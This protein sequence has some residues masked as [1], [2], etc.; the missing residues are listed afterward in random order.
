MRYLDFKLSILHCSFM[1]DLFPVQ[2]HRN[3]NQRKH[4]VIFFCQKFPTRL[5]FSISQFIARL[6]NFNLKV[7]KIT[8]F[9]YAGFYCIYSLYT[10]TRI[11]PFWQKYYATFSLGD[12]GWYVDKDQ[13]TFIIDMSYSLLVV[14]AGFRNVTTW[15][16]FSI[17][18]IF[19]AGFVIR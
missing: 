10:D 8:R 6:L 1:E 14:E 11:K 3:V 17:S 7:L 4:T 13:C 12:G 16:C 2:T 9:S 5:K 18:K 19:Y 15:I